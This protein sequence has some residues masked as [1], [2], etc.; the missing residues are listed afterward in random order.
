MGFSAGVFASVSRDCT[1]AYPADDGQEVPMPSA[2][3]K[4][5]EILG[6]DWFYP[7]QLPSGQVTPTYD[8][9]RLNAVHDTRLKMMDAVL[10]PMF[11]RD[12]SGTS[13]VDLA[14]HQ[15]YFALQMAERGCS[16]VLGVDARRQHV[17]DAA[18]MAE[19]QGHSG[20][21]SRQSDIHA[22]DT[23]AMGRFDI[24]LMLGLIYHLENPIGAIRAAAA[25]TGRVCLI[26]TQVVPGIT[27]NVD[28]GNYRFVKPLKGVFGIIDE[29]DETHGPEASTL[30][31]CLAPSTEGL[32]WVMQKVGFDRVELIAPPED[33]YEQHRYGKRVMVAGYRD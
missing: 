1:I 14:C 9:G 18:L 2:H 30:G 11:G 15:G 33:A 31:I 13:C 19:V 3:P 16:P 32:L 8:S 28:W 20:F 10:D 27:G 5:T 26:E 7:F 23:E 25:L 21:A 12:L 17:E 29:T 22:L 4:E 24:V 6:R